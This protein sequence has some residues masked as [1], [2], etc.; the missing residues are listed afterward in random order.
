[1]VEYR[2]PPPDKN[3]TSNAGTSMSFGSPLGLCSYKEA[4][5]FNFSPGQLKSVSAMPNGS[6]ILCL[7][8]SS[9]FSPETTSTRCPSTS[10]DTE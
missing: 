5:L 10:V 3:L 8:Y 2:P 6:K 1:M 7:K 4:N 9:N